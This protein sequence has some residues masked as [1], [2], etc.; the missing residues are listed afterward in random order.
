MRL[1]ALK[2]M[3]V[4]YCITAGVF[5]RTGCSI[6]STGDY[7]WEFRGNQLFIGEQAIIKTILWI[8]KQITTSKERNTYG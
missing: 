2:I 5:E 8:P 6:D 7:Y 3:T 4:N 1:I